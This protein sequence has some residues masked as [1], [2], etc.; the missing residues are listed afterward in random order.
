MGRI[1][2]IPRFPE[3]TDVYLE[4]EMSELVSGGSYV[5]LDF[6]VC[7]DI[8]VRAL[9]WSGLIDFEHKEG[10]VSGLVLHLPNSLPVGLYSLQV[11][12]WKGG[13]QS[14]CLELSSF[15]FV[16]S[17]N[18]VNVDYGVWSSPEG[19]LLKV[20]LCFVSQ[21]RVEG[22]DAFE[23]WKEL[24][25]NSNK[26]RQNYIDEVLDLHS[27][28]N[29]IRDAELLRVQAE[30][31]RKANENTRII[32]EEARELQETQRQNA[33][34]S[35]ASAESTR[36]SN[37][38]T[39]KQNERGRQAAETNRQEA[40]A[41][42]EI[43]FAAAIA[44][45]ENVNASLSG[46]TLTVTDRNGNSVT[47]DVQG[48]KGEKGD[49]GEQGLQGIQGER[50]EKG[51]DGRGVPAG[52]TT[53]K[54]LAKKSNSDYD[55]EWVEQTGG[56]SDVSYT[57][58]VR[59]QGDNGVLTIG[60]NNYTIVSNVDPTGSSQAFVAPSWGALNSSLAG[61]ANSNDLATVA[62]SGSYNDLT[63]KPTIPDVTGKADK[64]QSATNGHLA[65][66]NASG[67]LTDSGIAPSTLVYQGASQ[68][69]V[70][71][72]DFDPETDTVHVTA[73]T[74]SAAQQLQART[75]IGAAGV[76]D[77]VG[78]PIVNH[79]TSDKGTSSTSYSIAP[80]TLH[81]WGE[82]D[83]LYLS[84]TAG[85]VGY[86]QEYMIQFTSGST[87]TTLSLPNTLKWINGVTPSDIEAGKTYQVSIMNGIGVIG[88]A[89]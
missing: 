11:T 65:G 50:G 59:E 79:G 17:S 13:N 8:E 55:T 45:A 71:S 73:Q 64:V 20:D 4:A 85:T 16:R 72:V 40:E 21:V 34:R 82:V 43:D 42:R 22:K 30:N 57:Q 6:Y 31:Q 61:K 29:A 18:E 68:G 26:T 56:G 52:G 39:R 84:L 48:P 51:E 33:E 54:V 66:L 32:D 35:R 27:R 76:N 67:N 86:V 7:D 60:S 2:D 83:A 80:N 12:L 78:I 70:P 63:N 41:Q 87:A 44:G 88:G 36:V 58:Y 19:S 1:A 38:N 37:E 5:P 23:L 10:S 15:R 69:T 53:G 81:V 77:I 28:A 46:T 49:K 62:T 3:G 75:N 74:L 14:R 89:E 25:G 24:P 9:P 47:Q